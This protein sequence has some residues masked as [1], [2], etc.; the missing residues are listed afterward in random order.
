MTQAQGPGAYVYQGLW[1]NWSKGSVRG[2]TLTLS[3]GNGN[4]LI[5]VLA[6]FVALAGGQLWT[7]VRLLIHQRR[8]LHEQDDVHHDQEQIILRNTTTDMATAQSVLRLLRTTSRPRNKS[9]PGDVGIIF[10]AI[11]HLSFFVV[12]GT[13][14][15]SLADAG[16]AVLSRSPYC[17]T[18]NSTYDDTT[19]NGENLTSPAIYALS[20]ERMSKYA[21][22]TATSQQYAN[23]CYIMDP[24]FSASSSSDC[25]TLAKSTLNWTTSYNA[26]CP[27]DPK[28][29][30]ANCPT[31]VFD[32]G[33]IDTH[34]DLGLNADLA[35]RLYYRR[36]NKCTVLNGTSYTTVEVN[37]T[38][39][40]LVAYAWY[41][42]Q[43]R[44]GTNWTFS[45]SN[46][47]DFYTHNQEQELI[48]YYLSTEMSYY[49]FGG[50]QFNP[51][52]ELNT[53][54]ADV[55]LM[56]S[57]FAGQYHL[58]VDDE[59]FTAHQLTYPGHKTVMGR[60]GAY[61]PD[62]MINV[63]GCTEEHQ[64]CTTPTDCSPL[65]GVHSLLNYVSAHLNFTPNQNVTGK[66]LLDAANNAAFG[67]VIGQLS[68]T[69]TPFF[70]PTSVASEGLWVNMPLPD[71][72]WQLTAEY[73]HA[74]SLAFLQRGF[75]AYGTGQIAAKTEYLVSPTTAAGK[76]ICENLLIN[77]TTH[78]SFS[79]L[80]LIVLF[81]VGGLIIVLSLT[82]ED[83]VQWYY[84]QFHTGHGRFKMWEKDDML[85]LIEWKETCRKQKAVLEKQGKM[86]R[87]GLEAEKPPVSQMET[88]P[89]YEV[90]VKEHHDGEWV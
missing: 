13:F 89:K 25:N 72:Q 31:I 82:I 44:Y 56:F 29:C 84:R 58:P 42:N 17:G 37:E 1:T 28:V 7:V 81:L 88:L 16:Q 46:Y 26:T 36:V 4:L 35:S 11:F 24:L 51:I 10:V 69:S 38:T 2:L 74:I 83:A 27:F 62:K 86:L 85:K 59:L 33:I 23:E 15:S 14:S 20:T 64:M 5:A 76:W 19:A 68:L 52:P 41:G 30:S 43:W 79:V 70:P 3:S 90:V 49:G 53:S 71:N 63:L 67:N 55:T 12:A 65:L 78:Q 8:A 21:Q 22:D 54:S 87:K 66:R 50:Q 39:G 47:F 40:Q 60:D 9:L 18:F 61:K 57:G 75:V 77:V 32:T 34:S 45:T 73:W 80:V 6:L 48:Q